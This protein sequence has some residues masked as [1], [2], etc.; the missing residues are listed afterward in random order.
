MLKLSKIT[1]K[2]GQK[3]HERIRQP[4]TIVWELHRPIVCDAL[5]RDLLEA[6]ITR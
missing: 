3:V 5:K 4:V 1:H 6:D 2:L